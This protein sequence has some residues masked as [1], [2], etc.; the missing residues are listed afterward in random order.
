MHR[1]VLAELE[2]LEA[3]HNDRLSWSGFGS[4]ALLKE[5]A[6]KT[7]TGDMAHDGGG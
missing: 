6:V 2:A 4:M 1:V 3:I 5:Q 7:E